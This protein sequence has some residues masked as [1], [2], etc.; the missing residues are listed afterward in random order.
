ML[1]YT[2]SHSSSRCLDVRQ[3]SCPMYYPK[4]I[5]ARVSP[6]QLIEPLRILA[7]TRDLNQELLGPQSRVATTILPLHIILRPRN[8]QSF[9]A[10]ILLQPLNH[11]CSLPLD[12][13]QFINILHVLRS[14]SLHTAV[15]MWS[16]YWGN[17]AI[18]D[19]NRQF[20]RSLTTAIHYTLA[21]SKHIGSFL[22]RAC[23]NEN[24]KISSERER[25]TR[26][27]ILNWTNPTPYS[28][29]YHPVALHVHFHFAMHNKTTSF[30]G[31]QH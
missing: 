4:G 6:V 27:V 25:L 8:S 5:K 10:R 24:G 11:L 29:I 1:I 9:D 17:M 26:F 18:L 19:L 2:P 20:P 3:D 30:T 12:L 22:R 28:P 14:P 15:Q 21:S 23:L 31:M 7:L 16:H 13:L